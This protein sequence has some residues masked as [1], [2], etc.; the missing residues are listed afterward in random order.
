MP[1]TKEKLNDQ[2]RLL[3]A[4][5]KDIVCDFLVTA[6]HPSETANGLEPK[7]ACNKIKWR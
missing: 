5:V 2:S 6:G 7:K 3:F 1:L 4:L